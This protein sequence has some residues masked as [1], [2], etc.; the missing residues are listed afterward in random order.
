MGVYHLQKGSTVIILEDYNPHM[1]HN[2]EGYF[3]PFNE[4]LNS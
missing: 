2:P 4:E 1:A 3:M